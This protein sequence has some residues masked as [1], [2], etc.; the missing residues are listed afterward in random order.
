[1]SAVTL[2]FCIRTGESVA[3]GCSTSYNI[4]SMYV[5]R[6][7]TT[8]AGRGCS[9]REG[10]KWPAHAE[11]GER[12]RRRRWSLT[13]KRPR[14]VDMRKV[15]KTRRSFPLLAVRHPPI[16]RSAPRTFL[17]LYIWRALAK[18]I[19]RP[20]SKSTSSPSIWS[21]PF[22]LSPSAKDDQHPKVSNKQRRERL[23]GVTLRFHPDKFEG[24]VM[25][26]VQ[27]DKRSV[28]RE[29]VGVVA[30]TLDARSWRRWSKC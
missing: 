8:R 1:M 5:S 30:G 16:L 10:T 21:P 15:Y 28:V 25:P 3:A 11:E 7:D 29:A 12:R 6:R 20:P 24:P 18:N 22:L 13:Q 2:T 14:P 9:I 23:R 19:L 27:T 17:G 26:R 4:E